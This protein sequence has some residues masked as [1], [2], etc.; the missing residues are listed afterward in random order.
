M[1]FYTTARK[2]RGQLK[3]INLGASN[4]EDWL[5]QAA[6]WVENKWGYIRSFPGLE[7]RKEALRK[8]QDHFY[9]VTFAD[10][11][12]GMFALFDHDTKTKTKAKELMY[13]YVDESFRSL[14]IG[15]EM[16]NIVKTLSQGADVIILD[17][18]TPTL[19]KFYEKHGAKVVCDG[20]LLGHPTTVMRI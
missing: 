15:S 8:L 4:N 20:S 17:T 12:I 13:F 5:T 14:G 19:N 7:Y 11:P 2:F 10:Q 9:I 3:V 18:L 1:F 16:M 6:L